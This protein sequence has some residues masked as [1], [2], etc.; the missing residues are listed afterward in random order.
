[1]GENLDGAA[2]DFRQAADNRQPVTLALDN[3]VFNWIRAEFP[4]GWQEQINGLLRFYMD[5]SQNR[6]AEFTSTFDPGEMLDPTPPP[7]LTL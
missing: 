2:K 4:Q 1:M 5:T 7:E 3:D 6:E